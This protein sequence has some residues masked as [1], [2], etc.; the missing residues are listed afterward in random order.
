MLIRRVVFIVIITIIHLL[1]WYY[2][3]CFTH[4]YPFSFR[5]IIN[6]FLITIIFK[7]LIAQIVLSLIKISLKVL[8]KNSDGG[9]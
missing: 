8:S 2:I 5:G 7:H 9:L 4:I 1:S 6:V 3:T